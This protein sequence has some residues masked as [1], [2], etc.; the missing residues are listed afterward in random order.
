MAVDVDWTRLLP[1]IKN[2][3]RCSS[4]YSFPI[5]A[6][7]E[8]LYAQKDGKI[9]SF[10]EQELIDCS[11]D[12]YKG[13]SDGSINKG[14]AYIAKNGI[15]EESDYPYT[16]KNGDSKLCQV[17]PRNEFKIAKLMPIKRGYC[18]HMSQVLS[19]QPVVVKVDASNWGDYDQGIF[20]NC[21][22]KHNHG[23]L[24]VGRTKDYWL[25]RNS[26]SKSWGEYGYIRLAKG[27]T[28]GICEA[29][30]FPVLE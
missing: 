6:S 3:Y 16:S 20:D 18:Q 28:C 5:T 23:V 25:V 21:G 19:Q 24:L 4:C 9:R 17:L 14:F 15:N 30:C 22:T 29:A 7:V 8:A 13:C 1:P 2:Q 11:A 27:N 12:L 26:W 10:S